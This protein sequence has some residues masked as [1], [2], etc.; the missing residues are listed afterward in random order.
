MNAF[1]LRLEY[2]VAAPLILHLN[3][4]AKQKVAQ[5]VRIDRFR[6]SFG[7]ETGL[8]YIE[9]EPEIVRCLVL[10]GVYVDF[11]VSPY[12]CRAYFSD[13]GSSVYKNDKIE[14]RGAF[15][16]KNSEFDGEVSERGRVFKE[17][18]DGYF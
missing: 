12:A 5:T 18:Y 10:C 15:P 8:C 2:H 1:C 3:Q 9:R 6:L 4:I 11:S 13:S 7:V 14:E 16:T 17:K